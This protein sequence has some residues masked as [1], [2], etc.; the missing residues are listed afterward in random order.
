ME[1]SLPAGD[2]PANLESPSDSRF[3]RRTF[4]FRALTAISAALAAA[5]AIPVAGLAGSAAYMNGLR[6]RFLGTALPPTPRT[7]GFLPIGSVGDFEIGK[8]KLQTVTVPVEVEGATEPTPLSVY[9]L[10][11]DADR[12]LIM[13]LHCTHMGCPVGWSQGAERF[14]CPC[15]GGA[16]TAE[17]LRAA[18]PPPRRLDRYQALVA[19]QKVWMGPLIEPD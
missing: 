6:W 13:D 9:V 15:H 18:G 5:V 1:P 12:V 11:R 2:P 4:V 17:G 3:S 10:R 16:F 14:F 7:S 19:N 8:P